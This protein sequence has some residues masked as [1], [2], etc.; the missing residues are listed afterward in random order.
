MFEINDYVM[1]GLT[2]ACKVTDIRSD[3]EGTNKERKYYILNPLKD[4]DS[5]IMIPIMNKEIKLRKVI[6][7]E[8][9]ESL[10]KCSGDETIEWIDDSKE[11]M[12]EYG[13]LLKSGNCEVWLRLVRTLANEKQEKVH[14]GKKLSSSDETIYKTAL[15]LLS[16]EMALALGMDGEEIVP[17]IS[18][19]IHM[20]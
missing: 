8:D 9:A 18:R 10:L 13:E 1:Y 4:M 5:V 6:T 3:E 20:K 2:G 17:F 19:H 15:N 16:G 12:R 7:R 14:G 11:R